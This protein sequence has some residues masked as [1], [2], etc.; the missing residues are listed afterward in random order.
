MAGPRHPTPAQG[1]AQS[2]GER[3]PSM[4][5]WGKLTGLVVLVLLVVLI[6]ATILSGNHGP[7]RHTSAPAPT[8]ST[9][10]R[11]NLS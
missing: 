9:R 1:P 8:T 10:A 6:I 11:R 4:P 3:P 7:G 2:E 5:R